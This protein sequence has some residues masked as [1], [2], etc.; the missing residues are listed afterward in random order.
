MSRRG[1]ALFL[2]MC[3]I[4]GLPY[5]LIRVAVADVSPPTLVF[6]RTAIGA[7]L[8]MPLAVYRRQ[9]RTVLAAWRPLLAYTAIEIALPWVLLSDAETHLSS[10][11]SGLLVAAVPLVGTVILLRAG[12][13]E[14]PAG[15]QLLG[16][17]VGLAGVVAVLG[18]DLGAVTPVPALEM[19]VVVVCYAVGPQLLSRYLSHLPGVGVVACSLA[20]CAVAYLPAAI[21]LAPARPPSLGVVAALV[22][23]GVV[24]TAAAFILFFQLVSEVGAVRATVITYVNPAVA[25]L[26]GVTLLHERFG[27]GT[28]AGFAMIL[29]GSF[30]A[31]RV[32]ARPRSRPPRLAGASAPD[33]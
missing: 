22:A 5:F 3:V 25:V 20:L 16:L 6:A 2:A 32:V 9:L 10:S 15:P 27:A 23:L 11:L 18:F 26:L 21:L 1:W 8:L 14:H 4:W 30:L 31:T 19:A 12:R 33:P 28:A 7:L 17:L 29:I 24:C 13:S